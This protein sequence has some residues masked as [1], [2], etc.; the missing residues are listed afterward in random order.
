MARLFHSQK[1]LSTSTA[2][3]ITLENDEVTTTHS[4]TLSV[5]NIDPTAIVYVGDA[6]VTTSIYGMQLIPGAVA[7]FDQLSAYMDIYAV[8]D[9]DGSK[10]A[11]ITIQR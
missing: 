6:T 3:I 5:Q 4:V 8:S 10:V 2:H 11:T 9:T 1:T 7:T